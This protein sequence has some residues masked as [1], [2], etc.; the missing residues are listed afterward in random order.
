MIYWR[1][2]PGF[3]HNTYG[4]LGVNLVNDCGK[5]IYYTHQLVLEAFV[6]SCPPGFEGC[7]ND[8]NPRNNALY[9]LRYDTRGSNSRDRIKHG[10]NGKALTLED[11]ISIKQNETP[12]NEQ[13]VQYG[14]SK[15][16]IND[17]KRSRTWKSVMIES[18]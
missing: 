12:Q 8:N 17:I 11:V 10:T 4:H 6:G 5:I 14:V 7:H 15:Q 3:E 1:I 16:T 2:L 18:I 9:N 13:A